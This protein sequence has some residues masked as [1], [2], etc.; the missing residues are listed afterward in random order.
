MVMMV[1]E[2]DRTSPAGG[3]RRGH[4]GIFTSQNLAPF[5]LRSTRPLFSVALPCTR[6]EPASSSHSVVLSVAVFPDWSILALVSPSRHVSKQIRRIKSTQALQGA[7]LPHAF[8]CPYVVETMKAIMHRRPRPVW[9]R[10]P[11][12]VVYLLRA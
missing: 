10:Y 7:V 11:V 9:Q 8:L 6:P 12:A 1:L 2:R 3:N 5:Q 4:P